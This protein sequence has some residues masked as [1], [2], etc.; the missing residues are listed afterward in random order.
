MAK[1]VEN[2]QVSI[3][4]DTNDFNSQIKNIN[5]GLKDLEKQFKTLDKGLDSDSFQ[6]YALEIDKSRKAEYTNNQEN[7]SSPQIILNFFC[8]YCFSLLYTLYRK[9]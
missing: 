4:L 9:S 1:D 5:Q 7:V 3:S 2:L 8:I 6:H